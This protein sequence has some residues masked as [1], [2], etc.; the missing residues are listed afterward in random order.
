[1]KASR[2]ILIT[3]VVF[4]LTGPASAGP[5]HRADNI[6]IGSWATSQ[7]VPEPENALAQEDLQDATLRQIV[8]LSAGGRWLRVRLSNVFGAAPLHI[9][10][11]HIARAA[12]VGTAAIIPG[13]DRT[14]RFSGA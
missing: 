10:A 8:H 12:S 9:A 4:A 7:Q 5:R 2:L 14:L 13:S 3:V 11:A 1:M 6:W